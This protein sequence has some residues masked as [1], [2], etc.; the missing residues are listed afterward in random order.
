MGLENFLGDLK[1]QNALN[2]VSSNLIA[3][4]N[5]RC[6]LESNTVWHQVDVPRP[7]IMIPV[8]GVGTVLYTNSSPYPDAQVRY[9]TATGGICLFFAPGPWYV[10]V[11]LAGSVA[12]TVCFDVFDVGEAGN[13]LPLLTSI[14]GG[15]LIPVNVRQYGGTLQT[16]ADIGAYFTTLTH[17]PLAGTVDAAHV[18]QARESEWV[19]SRAGRRFY[20]SCPPGS[21][22]T[23]PATYA[24]T[25][26]AVLLSNTAATA[27]HILRS[28]YVSHVSDTNDPSEVVVA[29][30][31]ADRYASGGASRTP[32]NAY[33]QSAVA[34]PGNNAYE[35]PTAAA[36]TAQRTL[37]RGSIIQGKGQSLAA[38]F[39]DGVII[40]GAAASLLVYVYDSA[41][42]NTRSIRYALDMES[43]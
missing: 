21:T 41:G 31:S 14:T 28:L 4:G 35:A 8:A 38:G 26:P 22:V 6:F 33:M 7:S 25:T 3:R 24:A 15:G 34:W 9:L 12:A 29:L 10:Q 42:A 13:L 32:V 2:P 1:R 11:Q 37:F 19:S 40:S 16:G 39:D 17:G 43:Y 27:T 18:M 20:M 5:R 23:A 36:A 30:D